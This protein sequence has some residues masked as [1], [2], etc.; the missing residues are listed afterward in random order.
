MIRQFLIA[1]AIVATAVGEETMPVP[2]RTAPDEVIDSAVAA[3][4]KLGEEVVLGRYHVAIERMNPLWKDRAARRAGGM[5]ALQEQLEGV[6]REM[7]RR[8]VSVISSRP[9]GRPR[10][11]EVWPGRE[12]RLVDGQT[13][14]Q[15]VYKKWLV[16]VPTVTRYRILMEGEPRPIVIESTGFQIAV[17]EKSPLD[18]TFIDGASVTVNDLRSLF[19]TLPQDLELPPIERR[20]A[21]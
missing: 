4:R 3:V 5:E 7:V 1:S 14:D 11:F 6:A 18:W 21:R 15:L 19:R 10:V 16:F 20:E 8:G 2:A 17:S 13:V 9:D 12:A